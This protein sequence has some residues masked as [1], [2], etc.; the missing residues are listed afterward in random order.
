MYVSQ[1]QLVDRNVA[2]MQSMLL[3]IKFCKQG[4]HYE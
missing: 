4:T 1:I 2:L 3:E